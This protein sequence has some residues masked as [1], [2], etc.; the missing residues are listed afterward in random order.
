MATLV[1]R[2]TY[3]TKA[4]S[5]KFLLSIVDV[6]IQLRA[7]EIFILIHAALMARVAENRSWRT[8]RGAIGNDVVED[9]ELPVLGVELLNIVLGEV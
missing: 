4:Q 5:H 6:A 1:V 3:R 8:V 7:G 2:D 9:V